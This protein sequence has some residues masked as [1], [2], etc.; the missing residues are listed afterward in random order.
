MNRLIL[1]AIALSAT[2]AMAHPGNHAGLDLA[3]L[4]AHLF[5]ADHIIFATL[6]AIIGVLA[7]KAG[8]RAEA[9]KQEARHDPR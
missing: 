1:I 3:A 4:A 9:R 8:R 5:E 2:P 6:A 7:Y